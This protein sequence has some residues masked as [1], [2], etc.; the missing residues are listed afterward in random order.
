MSFFSPS[1]AEGDVGEIILY[2][3][4]LQATR[5]ARNPNLQVVITHAS[6]VCNQHSF[7]LPLRMNGMHRTQFDHARQYGP[8]IT[9]NL[10]ARV[11]TI[12]HMKRRAL[13]QKRFDLPLLSPVLLNL[14]LLLGLNLNF[15]SI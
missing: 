15:L 7:G 14:W 1:L 2:G 9:R 10:I 13:E 8:S 4:L 5:G 6:H 3:T 12:C 11:L